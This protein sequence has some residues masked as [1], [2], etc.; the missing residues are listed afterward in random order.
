VKA[1]AKTEAAPGAHLIDVDEPSTP[2]GHVKIKVQ[3]T[4]ICGTD[5][6]I[7][8][9]D[10]WA[11]GRIKPPRVIGHEWCGFVHEI[12]EG[13]TGLVLGDYVAGESHIVCNE[14][15]QCRAGQGHV[16]ANTRIIGVD[17]DGCFQPYFVVPAQNAR[18]THPTIPPDIATIQ[19]PLGNAI[20]TTLAGPVEGVTMLVLGMGPIGLFAVGVAKACGAKK[21][22][23][24]EVSDYRLNMALRMDADLLMN[25]KRDDIVERVLAETDGVGV[26]VTLEMSGHPAAFQQA[27][28]ATRAGGRVSMLG[29]FPSNLT[30]DMDRVIFKGLELQGIVGRRLWETWDIMGELLAS[31]R[32]DVSPVIT[33][34]LHYTEFTKA[35]DLITAG[36]CGKVVFTVD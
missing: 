1:I 29:I 22:F 28:A 21:V 23:V 12:G 11:A 35:M 31:R 16:C 14:C 19:D 24:T 34:R 36:E 13:V 6:H 8:T 26:D 17:I 27:V 15:Y 10:P 9:W 30:V 18:K 20:H 3:R 32:L 2:P 33:H 7:Y 4:S 5:Y 25:P